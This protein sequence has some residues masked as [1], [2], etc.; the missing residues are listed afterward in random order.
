MTIIKK[1]LVVVVAIIFV[2]VFVFWLFSSD[3]QHIEDTNGDDNY[4]LQQITDYNIIKMDT[5]ALN[6][7]ESNELFNNLPTYKSEKYTG[8]SEI[9][10]NNII[11]NR[12]EI[13][14]YNTTVNKG[15]FRI[16][17]VYNDEIVHEFKLNELMQTYTLEDV[18][19]T[20]SL[21]VA[22]E[23]ADFEFSYDVI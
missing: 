23:S 22:G 12:F 20:V 5:G 6:L 7:V 8:V 19:G 9:Y 1:L 18:K 10:I 14:L 16:V 15:N 4:S 13:T 17:L 11:T 21:R 2:T 3:T